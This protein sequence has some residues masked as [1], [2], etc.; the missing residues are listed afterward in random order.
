MKSLKDIRREEALERQKER[1]SRSAQQQLA[2]LDK[3]LGKGV[4]ASKE[5][6]RLQSK[7]GDK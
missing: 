5:R 7:I 6:K 2:F 1:D 4:G 3:R